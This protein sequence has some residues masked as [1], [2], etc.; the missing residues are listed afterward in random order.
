VPPFKYPNRSHLPDLAASGGFSP[1][2]QPL[3]PALKRR[4]R[5]GEKKGEEEHAWSRNRGGSAAA[6]AVFTLLDCCQIGGEEEE[7]EAQGAER[8]TDAVTAGGRSCCS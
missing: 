8:K 4:R 7:L 2:P 5:R 3:P 6:P 1:N